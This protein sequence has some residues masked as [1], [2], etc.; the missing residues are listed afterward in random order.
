MRLRIPLLFLL[1]A[2]SV[3]APAAMA[4]YSRWSAEGGGFGG[5][6]QAICAMPDEERHLFIGTIRGGIYHSDGTGSGWRA[7]NHGLTFPDVLSLAAD[8]TDPDTLLAGTGGGGVFRS[9][10][11]GESWTPVNSGLTSLIVRKVHFAS[12][13]ERVLV[14]TASGGLFYSDDRGALW[15]SAN[16]GLTSLS[17]QSVTCAPSL[18]DR[19][20]AATDDGVFR[21]DNGGTTWS[22]QSSGLAPLVVNDLIVHP[23]DEDIAYAALAGGGVYRTSDAG[24]N[25]SPRSTGL[26]PAYVEALRFA[27]GGADT[28]WAGTQIGVY[29]TADAGSSWTA[30]NSG[31]ADTVALSLLALTDSVYVGSYWG[32]VHGSAAPSVWW[33]DRNSGLA[34]R[35][36]WE[37]A[38]SP[39]EGGKAWA[40]SYGGIAATS[41]TGRTWSDASNG[42]NHFD[43]RAIDVDPN[44]GEKLLAGAF[45]GGVYRSGDGGGLWSSSS[46][47]LSANPTVTTL[48]YRPGSSSVVLAGTYGGPY[49]STNG[50]ISWAP[51]WTGMGPVKV[52]GLATGESTPALVF[53]GTYGDGFFKSVDFGL[54]WTALPAPDQYVRAVAVDPADS[55]IVYAGGYYEDSG[56][57]GIHKSTDGGWT[58][59]AANAGLGNLSIW[60]ITID[61]GDPEH[62]VA[63]TADGIYESVDGAGSWADLS[64]GLWASDV[65]SVSF[66]GNRMIAATYGG[67]TPWYEEGIVGIAEG[68]GAA[69]LVPMPLLL[70][71]PNPFNPR[72]VLSARVDEGEAQ[73][74]IHDAA[75]RL[76]RVLFDGNA[77]DGLL[78]RAWNGRDSSGRAVASG[79]YVATL[80]SASGSATK[81]IILIR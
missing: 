44:D 73:I 29:R 78:E 75:G 31:L 77:R 63:G 32:G 74:A 80:R 50:G 9:A 57:G 71:R 15:T 30:C 40:V 23:L 48:R 45:Y 55:S 6:V 62:L 3:M 2:F 36:A 66:A 72:A 43:L 81:R 53:A 10:N 37:I 76:V 20:Y 49:R 65:R 4:G 27:P 25:W 11:R 12:D 68:T 1:A 58:W 22:Y 46:S 14:A 52:W 59:T 47:G 41:D 28:I 16:S 35:F 39:D 8:P 67:S 21:S 61:P 60:S 69:A 70:V 42:L 51:S 24:A 34:N 54:T 19:W 18:A 79:V 26:G 33:N 5:R 17:A 64:A 13:G 7:V 38:S 56:Q